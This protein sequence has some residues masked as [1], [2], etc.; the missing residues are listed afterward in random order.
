MPYLT[1][2]KGHGFCQ[3]SCHDGADIFCSCFGPCCPQPYVPR[4]D[5]R[6]LPP[7]P[8]PEESRKRAKEQMTAMRKAF[9]KAALLLPSGFDAQALAKDIV[10]VQPMVMAARAIQDL[11]LLLGE[12]GPN[13]AIRISGGSKRPCPCDPGVEGEACEACTEA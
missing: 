4:M 3:C 2:K 13:A 5:L 7:R 6:L 9:A 11:D 10:S 1:D 12:A 8:T